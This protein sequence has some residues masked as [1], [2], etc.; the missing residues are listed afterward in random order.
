[1]MYLITPVPPVGCVQVSFNPLVPTFVYATTGAT[2]ELDKLASAISP[3]KLAA[4]PS[5]TGSTA[6][7]PQ[8]PTLDNSLRASKLSKVQAQHRPRVRDNDIIK[9]LRTTTAQPT[10]SRRRRRRVDPPSRRSRPRE[11]PNLSEQASQPA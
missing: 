9:S 1:M 3:D 11:F 2:G 5:T 8:N 7:G 6:N 10:I 4:L